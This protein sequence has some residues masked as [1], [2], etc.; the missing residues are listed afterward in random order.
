MSEEN[1]PVQGA[2]RAALSVTEAGER[3]VYEV[4]YLL[5]PSIVENDVP[6]EV[7]G[8]KD[9]IEKEGAHSISEEFP[10]FRPL[11]YPMRKH[12]G[13]AWEQYSNAY[14][15]WIKFEGTGEEAK[16]IEAGFRRTHTVLRYLLV[17]TVREHVL[18]GARPPRQETPR[19][20]REA[21]TS[22]ESSAPVSEAELDQ[23]IEKLI[24]E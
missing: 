18:V 11:A 9:I 21:L 7:T 5:L 20:K 23:S 2:E 24:A 19:V 10:K 3:R 1:T 22:A 8:L 15:G 12:V 14:F 4:G 16:R 6:R 17:K 13:S